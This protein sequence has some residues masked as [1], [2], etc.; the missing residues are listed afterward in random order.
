MKRWFLALVTL[1]LL[2]SM[3]ACTASKNNASGTQPSKSTGNNSSSN[4]GGSGS[5]KSGG[6][7]TAGGSTSKKYTVSMIEGSWGNPLP[8]TKGPAVTE[9]DQKYNIDFKP[10]FV[11]MSDYSTNKL[12]VVIASGNIPDIIG[13]EG[14]DANFFKW[15]QEGAFLPLN[16]YLKDGNYPGFKNIPQSVWNMVSQNGKIYAIPFYFPVK[17]GKKAFIRQDWLD[18]LGLKM[19][20]NYQELV[21]VAEAF[22]NED[23][24][25]DHKKDTYGLGLAKPYYYGIWMGAY[26][27]DNGWYSKNAQGQLI[28]TQISDAMK[29]EMSDLHTLY[30]DGAIDPDWAT[31]SVGDERNAFYAGKIG[32][33]YDQLYDHSSDNYKA[34]LKANPNA[35]LAVMPPFKQP[36]GKQG[37]LG[38]SGTYQLVALNGK[39][40]NNPDEIKRILQMYSDATTFIPV[41]Q[42]GP[43]NKLFDWENGG[44]GKGYVMTNGVPTDVKNNQ[45]LK[46]DNYLMDRGWAPNDEANEIYKSYA[47]PGYA[48]FVKQGVDTLSKYKFYIDPTYQI[49]SPVRDKYQTDLTNYIDQQYTLLITGTKPMSDW[50]AVVQKYMD[51]G[52]KAMIDDVNK[53][54]KAQGLKGQWI[55]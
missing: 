48:K 29:Q 44:V 46:P 6:N 52:G 35:K 8:S 45:D 1:V 11:P 22:A 9:I 2:V 19:P 43:N 40:K 50:N 17:Y 27:N 4:S 25:G 30:K 23:P 41:D 7:Q 53:R 16:K 36:D 31:T 12:P 28:P 15:A 14:A 32:I 20:T 5:G 38:L 10:Q 49:Y 42:R 34:L 24:N 51:Q 18:N 55:Q 26:W 3:T 54:L 37:Y 33:Y 47:D 13:M 21:K 39:L